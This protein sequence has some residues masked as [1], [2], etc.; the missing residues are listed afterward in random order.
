MSLLTVTKQFVA[1]S[2]ADNFLDSS[3]VELQKSSC[4]RVGVILDL[5]L[6]VHNSH[7]NRVISYNLYSYFLYII[8][9][10]DI[11]VMIVVLLSG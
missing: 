9:T 11:K 4:D 8:M 10:N 2:I 5:Y 3:S 1:K 6:R 7:I